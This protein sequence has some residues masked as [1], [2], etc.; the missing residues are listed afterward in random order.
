MS[1]LTAIALYFLFWWLTLF[2]SLPFRMRTQQ[3]EGD[4]A[5]GTEPSAPANPQIGKRLLANTVIAAV[6]FGLYW[7]VTVYLGFGIEDF[8]DFISVD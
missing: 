7:F 4:I 2:I 1:W 6:L 3:D 5:P 8:P